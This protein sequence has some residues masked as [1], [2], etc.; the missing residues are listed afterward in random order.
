MDRLQEAKCSNSPTG[1][2]WWMIESL[3]ATPWA[4]CKYCGREKNFQGV[5]GADLHK[6]SVEHA[7]AVKAKAKESALYTE[8]RE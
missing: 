5:F 4:Y 1:V 2:H 3:G 8:Y 7:A 6:Y